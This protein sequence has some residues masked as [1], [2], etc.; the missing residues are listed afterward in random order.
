MNKHKHHAHIDYK[1]RLLIFIQTDI[2]DED[3][4]LLCKKV[5]DFQKN[6]IPTEDMRDFELM[7]SHLLGEPSE[8][9]TPE[10]VIA[11]YF[12]ID[13]NTETYELNKRS[14]LLT[15]ELLTDEDP[16]LCACFAFSKSFLNSN[17][18]I[19]KKILE[20]FSFINNYIIWISNSNTKVESVKNLNRIKNIVRI[21]SN[22]GRNKVIN[23]YGDYFSLLLSKVGLTGVNSGF[24]TS[25]KKI[26][27][28]SRGGGG[29]TTIRIYSPHIYNSLHKEEFKRLI[30]IYSESICDCDKCIEIKNG[31]KPNSHNFLDNYFELLNSNNNYEE[32]FILC[33]KKEKEFVEQN[34]LDFLISDLDSKGEKY[35]KHPN[36]SHLQNW[37][38]DL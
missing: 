32:H 20:D 2:S 7:Y 19:E 36:A 23:L 21:L 35:E 9:R 38:D 30:D 5:I 22:E 24:G 14:I 34:N 27:K 8:I 15:H 16:P 11:P 25:T 29:G 18:N 31:L 33:R 26:A 4:R 12:R 10:Y 3:L 13:K 1:K 37:K 28:L 6:F 17:P